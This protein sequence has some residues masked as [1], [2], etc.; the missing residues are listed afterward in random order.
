MPCPL[1][2]LV[3]TWPCSKAHNFPNFLPCSIIQLAGVNPTSG[4]SDPFSCLVRQ[5]SDSCW[6][7]F[8]PCMISQFFYLVTFHIFFCELLTQFL[9]SSAFDLVTKTSSLPLFHTLHGSYSPNFWPCSTFLLAGHLDKLTTSASIIVLRNK[10]FTNRL[11][12]QQLSKQTEKKSIS[13]YQKH[14]FRL[15][16]EKH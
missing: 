2:V 8:W 6:P 14:F 16:K 9:A 1:L 5:S 10:Y 11:M 3:N 12:V 15:K 13:N 4:L 7:H